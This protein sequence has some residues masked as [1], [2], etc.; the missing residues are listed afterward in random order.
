[1]MQE[2]GGTVEAVLFQKPGDVAKVCPVCESTLPA[3]LALKV[4]VFSG[5]GDSDPVITIQP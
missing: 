1:M 5:D 3:P 2:P 4:Q